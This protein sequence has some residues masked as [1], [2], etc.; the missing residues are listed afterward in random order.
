MLVVPCVWLTPGLALA[1]SASPQSLPELPPPPAAPPLATPPT[2][3]SPEEVSPP[4]AQSPAPPPPAAPP[5]PAAPPTAEGLPDEMR[6]WEG[7][8]IPPGYE[9]GSR[10]SRRGTLITGISL[11]GSLYAL[12]A[13]VA[14]K[15]TSK[16]HDD[17]WPLYVPIV[18]PFARLATAEPSG[19]DGP[20]GSPVNDTLGDILLVA[21]GLGQL[22]GGVLLGVG[23]ASSEK[24]LVR[25]PVDAEAESEEASVQLTVRG[26][27]VLLEGRF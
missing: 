26:Q 21:D 27:R 5:S 11:L 17:A 25:S 16:G 13:F 6:Y 23:L 7:A 19:G 9:L 20:P 1:Q 10:Y 24:V 22:T 2:V 14:A 8:P 12:S 15:A 3:T 18:G 4:A